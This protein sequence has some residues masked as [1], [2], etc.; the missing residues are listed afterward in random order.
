MSEYV[1]YTVPNA[2]ALSEQI[3]K[4]KGDR[5]MTMFADDIKRSSPNVKVSASTIS[6]ACNWS[7]GNPVSKELLEA[8]ARIADEG[9]GVTKETLLAANGMRSKSEASQRDTAARRRESAM[10]TERSTAMIIQNEITSRGYAV[11]KLIKLY[12]GYSL[13]GYVEQKDRV[14]PRNYNFGFSVSG[15]SPCSTWKFGFCPMS[16]SEDSNEN[17]I[18]A[19]VGNFINRIASVFASD[20]IESELYET[21]KYSFVFIDRKIYGAFLKRINSHE[22][23]VNGLLTA[24]LVDLKD[25]C[26]LEETQLKRYDG[27]EAS[28]FFK[29]AI[30]QDDESMEL[31]EPIDFEDEGDL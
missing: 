1:Q 15:M 14:F 13:H 18:E 2:Q 25:W 8:I 29:G 24:I 17:A 26:V 22:M 12:N 16:L 19:Y 21:E 4:V 20:S 6:R 31:F 5:S 30:L 23:L 10:E 11:R 7:G 9:T 27:A 3:N 28:S